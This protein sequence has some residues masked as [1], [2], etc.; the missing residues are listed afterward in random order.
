MKFLAVAFAAT[1]AV[2]TADDCSIDALSALLKNTNLQ[3]CGTEASYSFVPPTKPTEAQLKGMCASAACNALL[4]D[5]QKLNLAECT[6]PLGDK[7]KLRADLI[8]YAAN[9]CKSSGPAPTPGPGPLPTPSTSGTTPGV[10]PS[11]T[12]AKPAC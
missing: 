5:V 1:I 3:K 9:Y 7:I 11:V 4:A 12:T 10:T 6:V 8:D 2:A